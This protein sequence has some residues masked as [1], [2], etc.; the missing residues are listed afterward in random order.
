MVALEQLDLSNNELDTLPIIIRANHPNLNQL[1]VYNN[2]LD[3]G[4]L[5]RMVHPNEFGI[6][7]ESF[8]Y[9]PQKR[10][11][12]DQEYLVV[13]GESQT[14][15][16]GVERGVDYSWFRDDI[17]LVNN[18]SAT[19]SIDFM[20]ESDEGVYRAEVRNSNVPN[21]VVTSILTNI[22][23]ECAGN[24]FPNLKISTNFQTK[25]C[26]N[27]AIFAEITLDEAIG[28]NSIQWRRNGDDILGENRATLTIARSGTYTVFATDEN[29]C[30]SV[31]NPIVISIAPAPQVVTQQ[32]DASTLRATVLSGE[33]GG[34][35][36]WLRNGSEI[37]DA[38]QATFV[39][40]EPANYQV[41]FTAQNGCSDVSEQEFVT[42]LADELLSNSTRIY[43][44]PTKGIFSL[45]F[46]I[47]LSGAVGYKIYN[48]V[49][50]L[51]K[52]YSSKGKQ[53]VEMDLIN[54]PTGIYYV[55]IRSEGATATKR[56]SKN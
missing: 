11:L 40:P 4:D 44:N 15:T 19:Y 47:P 29:G 2:R 27:E 22:L 42:N 35:F 41:R 53:V 50:V 16:T 23:F 24:L 56:I 46:N 48:S 5:I 13:G 54:Q 37:E 6:N 34:T 8:T 38:N 20:N 3:F 33:T 18:R 9:A 14:I 7:Q 39:V 25:F 17:L 10:Q 31:S 12:P 49:G 28:S 43:P 32:M 30:S 51:V 1:S 21:L 52:E 26:E 36:Q 55:E 45:E